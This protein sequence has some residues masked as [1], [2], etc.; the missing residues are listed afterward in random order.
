[1]HWRMH[2]KI[3]KRRKGG[4]VLFD[5]RKLTF[6]LQ[7]LTLQIDAYWWLTNIRKHPKCVE[8]IA[9]KLD[10]FSKVGRI[11]TLKR[12]VVQKV[13]M[14]VSTKTRRPNHV[15]YGSNISNWS[16]KHKRSFNFSKISSIIDYLIASLKPSLSSLLLH[17]PLVR[18]GWEEGW[19]RDGEGMGRGGEA[20]KLSGFQGRAMLP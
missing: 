19:G 13:R 6:V 3:F 11:P 12:C 8:L 10:I 4:Y 2:W 1:M 14:K 16:W 18:R 7:L 9:S 17:T 15:K 20:F 5:T